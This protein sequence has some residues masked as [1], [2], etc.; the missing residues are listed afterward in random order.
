MMIL[1]S[2]YIGGCFFLHVCMYNTCVPGI[3][4]SEKRA[5]DPLES[6]VLL[7]EGHHVLEIE[8]K[9]S[10]RADNTLRTALPCLLSFK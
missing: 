10:V 6:E 8:P 7:I 1:V 3:L 5:S 9:S 4:G 2:F